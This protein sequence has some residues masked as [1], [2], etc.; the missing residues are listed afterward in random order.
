MGKGAKT[1][2]G[3]TLYSKE[4]GGAPGRTRTR[5]PRFRKP[6]THHSDSPTEWANPGSRLAS[7]FL[8]FAPVKLNLPQFVPIIVTNWS[9][10]S[11]IPN[12]YLSEAK[13]VKKPVPVL[14]SSPSGVKVRELT[15]RLKALKNRHTLSPS[16]SKCALNFAKWNLVAAA[17]NGSQCP[18]IRPVEKTVHSPQAQS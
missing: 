14:S 4:I 7:S 15:P 17:L 2:D 10:K 16:P 18:W 11:L 8:A 9:Q 13:P 1:V 3:E 5:G 12:N 6:M